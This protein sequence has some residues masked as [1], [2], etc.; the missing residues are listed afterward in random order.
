MGPAMDPAP[1]L[2]S[3][4]RPAP[5]PRPG[6]EP[7]TPPR[8]GDGPVT[9]PAAGDAQA[10]A[11]LTDDK[12]GRF[13]IYQ[14]VMAGAGGIARDLVVKTAGM[15]KDAVSDALSGGGAQNL[16]AISAKALADSGLTQP[17]ATQ[18]SLLLSEYVAKRMVT[19]DARRALAKASG[20]LKD[21]Y[22]KQVDEGAKH[23]QEFGEK[24]GPAAL[25]AVDKHEAALLEAQQ[26]L[27]KTFL[28]PGR[29]G[30]GR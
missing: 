19:L 11:L 13:A 14:K 17:E 16:A 27:M 26:L 7:A 22:Q 15:G 24:Y 28:K 10:Q 12:I 18:L 23:R 25:A 30:R 5:P 20:P 29:K 21:A 6:D 2:A 1:D 8:P 9:Q 3:A 4:D